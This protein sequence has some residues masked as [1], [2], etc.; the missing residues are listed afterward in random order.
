MCADIHSQNGPAILAQE[1]LLVEKSERSFF[2]SLSTLIAMAASTFDVDAIVA[3]QTQGVLPEEAPATL[4]NS[5]VDSFQHVEAVM[6]EDCLSTSG[7]DSQDWEMVSDMVADTENAATDFFQGQHVLLKEP[8]VDLKSSLKA[9]EETMANLK[10]GTAAGGVETPS[11]PEGAG[12]VTDVPM[13]TPT[14]VGNHKWN[15]FGRGSKSL[16]YTLQD[17]P[18]KMEAVP[19]LDTEEIID[20]FSKFC[21]FPLIPSVA[22]SRVVKAYTAMKAQKQHDEVMRQPHSHGRSRAGVGSDTL[23]DRPTGTPRAT[24]QCPDH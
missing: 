6:K 24:H 8:E 16:T 17:V 10:L 23:Q 7:L 9:M 13:A 5:S 20:L 1:C 4:M 14:E 3:E 15:V 19:S 11:G 2:L 12:S 18:F 21:D 22:F